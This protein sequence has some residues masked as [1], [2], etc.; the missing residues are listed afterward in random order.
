MTRNAEHTPSPQSVV[1]RRADLEEVRDLLMER[2]YG[3][4]ARSPA[5]NA[6]LAVEAMLAA[7]PAP[8]SLAGGEVSP[9]VQRLAYGYA[10]MHTPAREGVE[11]ALHLKLIDTL[12]PFAEVAEKLKHC[13][14]VE[15]CEP[16]HDNP[17]RNIIPMPREWFERAADDLEVI[18]IQL[19]S[20]GVLSEGQTA[21][22]TGLDRVEVRKQVDALTPRHEAPAC[23]MCNGR[24]EVG[25]P[26]GQTPESFEYVT[27]C[28]PDCGGTGKHEAPAE[29]A[30]ED[31]GMFLLMKRD[32]YYRPAAQGYT[33]I[34]DNAGRYTKAEAEEHADE[35][36]G[37]TAILAT[38]A[39]EFS[40]A[41][42]DDLARAHLT[43]KLD[44]ARREIDALRARSSAPE[45]RE[46]EAVGEIVLSNKFG[47][48]VS[49]LNGKLPPLGSKLYTHPAAP[50]ADHAELTRLAEAA[51]DEALGN[52]LAVIHGD[53]GHRALEV[54]TKQAALEAEQIVAGLFAAPSADKLRAV[55]EGFVSDLT[56]SLKNRS[57][58]L[59]INHN[60]LTA[61]IDQALAVLKAEV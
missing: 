33:G 22:L 35:A 4:N 11:K 16:T 55:V 51:G 27:E 12:K 40:P 60:A 3:S 59:T 19:H 28:C 49:W 61:R 5:H 10:I 58:M 6:R 53:G 30:G 25:G 13:H 15:I 1:V 56:G 23:E 14:V 18:A 34:K 20:D 42:F 47:S 24:G 50:S 39:P 48:G 8:S 31:D 17:S 9:L 54:G 29:G 36:Y 2:I 41:C 37:V 52:L 21:K 32:L 45:A 46:G 43:K 57:T 26:T 44:E 38:E 7:A